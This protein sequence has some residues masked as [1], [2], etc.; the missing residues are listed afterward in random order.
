M[1]I[2]HAFD[3]GGFDPVAE[4][5]DLFID[6]PEVRNLA[7]I[8]IAGQIARTIQPRIRLETERIGDEFLGCQLRAVEIT[9]RHAQAADAKLAFCARLNLP[10]ILVKNVNRGVRDRPADGRQTLLVDVRPHTSRGSDHSAFRRAIVIDQFE[11]QAA[12]RITMQSV[13]TRQQE[14]QRCLP[15]PFQSHH[16]FSQSR[17]QKADRDSFFH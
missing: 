5:V 4:N 3:F 8:E 1:A 6:A 10:K 9:A 2:Q 11:R 16:T 14:S 17:R 15:R 7:V 12:G 13:G